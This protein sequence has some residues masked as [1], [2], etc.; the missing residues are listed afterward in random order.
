MKTNDRD[1]MSLIRK[2]IM[3]NNMRVEVEKEVVWNWDALW[4]LSLVLLLFPL[5]IREVKYF[6]KG[7]K[8]K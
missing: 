4:Q 5:W 8:R 2:R 6:K 7:I 1:M 3:E